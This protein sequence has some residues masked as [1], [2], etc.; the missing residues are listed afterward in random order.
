MQV[1]KGVVL[2]ALVAMP[3]MGLADEVTNVTWKS[4]LALGAT[5]KQGNT[6]KTLYTANLKADR[7]APDSDWISSL[8]AENGETDGEQTEDKIRLQSDYRH[9]FGGSKDWFGG[10]F[11]EAY[12]DELK[13]IRTRLKIGP[14]LG[15]YFINKAKMK[16]DASLGVNYV[17]RRTAA[18]EDHFGEYRA[19]GNY[20]WDFTET[21]SYYCNV[22]YSVRMDDTD[23]GTGLLV[24]G[25]KSKMNSHLALFVELRDEYDNMPDPGID[26]N[27]LTI[28]AGLTYDF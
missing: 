15:Y 8:Y 25:L 3:L 4:S 24:T 10:V 14:N 26:H 13:N 9:K 12:Y 17:Y 7:Y 22:E 28:I 21:A 19:A 6:D 16:L 18:E 27:D 20:L 11:G 23:D 5:F 2:S 1:I